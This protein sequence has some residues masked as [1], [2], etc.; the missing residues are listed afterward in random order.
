MS[1]MTNN[2][3]NQAGWSYIGVLLLAVLFI[4]WL[5]FDKFVRASCTILYWIWRFWADFI[6]VFGRHTEALESAV[7]KT[8]L[9]ARTANSAGSVTYM[10]W[11]VVM[12][13]TSIIL[14]LFFI[15]LFCC[16]LY[17]MATHPSLPYRSKRIINIHTLPEIAMRNSPALAP[18]IADSQTR[19]L[20]MNDERP[21]HRWAMHPEEFAENHKLIREQTLN[22]DL[23]REA[24]SAQLGP[25]ITT[26]D[27]LADYEK[28]L[29]AV[30]GLQALLK[31]RKQAKAILDKLNRSCLGRDKK[32]QRVLLRPDFDIAK[33]DF[34]RVWNCP[35][36][37]ELLHTHR[38]VRTALTGLLGRDIRLPGSQYRWLKGIDRT[39]WYALHSSDTQSGFIEGAGVLAQMR[40]ERVI[41]REKLSSRD[42]YLETAIDGLQRDLESL[43]LV[44]KV[45]PKEE[46]Q[47]KRTVDWKPATLSKESYLPAEQL[48]Q[49]AFDETPSDA[50]PAEISYPDS[51]V[52]PQAPPPYFGWS[53]ASYAPDEIPPMPGFG[54][55]NFDDNQFYDLEN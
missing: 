14:L 27:A 49:E 43:G 2:P 39:L 38:F 31:D 6:V 53:E 21:E 23:T 35:E 1:R 45:I 16:G 50:L 51:S 33:S 18:I 44:H 3:N 40:F 55:N 30:F 37:K 46:I 24:L 9:L 32:R 5:W 42:I 7:N 8:N 25:E 29:F 10:Q 11:Y 4:C 28:A 17:S 19:D 47:K 26:A 15:P 34:E 13:Q 22:R 54:E 36:M 48:F 20:L 41:A 12:D 52:P